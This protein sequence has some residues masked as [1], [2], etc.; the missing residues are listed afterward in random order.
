VRF[1]GE[2]FEFL[3][4]AFVI[5]ELQGKV[6]VGSQPGERHPGRDLVIYR[7]AE[8]GATFL[9]FELGSGIPVQW[10]SLTCHHPAVTL[11]PLQADRASPVARARVRWHPN[12]LASDGQTEDLRFRLRLRGLPVHNFHQRV[13]W[14]RRQPLLCEPAGLVVPVLS[15]ERPAVHEVHVT[16]SDP[17]PL[18]LQRIESSVAWV[19][20][21]APSEPLPLDPGQNARIRL[22]VHPAALNGAS[23]PHLGQVA[24]VFAGRGRQPFSVRVDAVRRVQPLPG[25]LLIDP[26]PPRI[27]LGR[28]DSATREVVYLPC[29]GDGGLEPAK[30]G[31]APQE[32]AGAVHEQRGSRA[33]CRELI[34]RALHAVRE[35]E[36]REVREVLVCSRPWLANVLPAENRFARDW[37]SLCLKWAASGGQ[38]PAC[39]IRLDAWE[40][41]VLVCDQEPRTEK[42]D[43]GPSLGSAVEDWLRKQHRPIALPASTP[44]WLRLACDEFLCDYRW[45]AAHAWRRLLAAWREH[46]ADRRRPEFHLHEA[47]RWLRRC[48]EDQARRLAELAREMIAGAGVRL[49]VSPLFGSRSWAELVISSTRS[50]GDEAVCLAPAW[51]EWLGREVNRSGGQ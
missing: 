40:A 39:L 49:W 31:L 18:V 38:S 10:E 32:Y 23:A 17:Q 2:R 36:Q 5:D 22:E 42:H 41:S 14:R 33:L 48:L 26:G 27:V 6:W 3:I 35:R 16:N 25:P 34:A 30:L 20:E 44:G 24:F 43:G 19:T 13:S 7:G 21:A 11:Q 28:W 46:L 4:H 29:S 1:R 15:G 12:R 45:G 51:V 8:P 9:E 50:F 37:R 47:D